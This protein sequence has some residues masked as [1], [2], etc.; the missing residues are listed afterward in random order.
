M[1]VAEVPWGTFQINT[2]EKGQAKM[3]VQRETHA[4]QAP[5]QP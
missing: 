2:P 1:L 4:V 3:T 5:Q